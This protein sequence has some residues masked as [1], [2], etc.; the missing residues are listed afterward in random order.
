MRRR[1]SCSLVLVAAFSGC[2]HMPS[3]VRVDGT[4]TR[5]D[6]NHLFYALPRTVVTAEIPITKRIVAPGRCAPY[7]HVA[8]I[9]LGVPASQIPDLVGVSFEQGKIVL[10]SRT[11]PDPEQ[12]FAIETGSKAFQNRSQ[13]LE[14]SEQ[15]FLLGGTSESQSQ[16]ATMAV[17]T[18]STAATLAAKVIPMGAG[19]DTRLMVKD[20]EVEDEEEAVCME[21]A[22][23]IQGIRE[24]RTSL[25]EG[26]SGLLSPSKDA[27]EFMVGALNA[28][29]AR[30]LQNFTGTVRTVSA[31]I[32][33]AF[34]PGSRFSPMSL[35]IPNFMSEPRVPL[36]SFSAFLGL[37]NVA[38]ELCSV[39]PEFLMAENHKSVKTAVLQSLALALE[40]NLEAVLMPLR[41]EI[42]SRIA[43]TPYVQFRRALAKNI[44]GK[45]GSPMASAVAER[46]LAT[47]PSRTGGDTAQGDSGKQA[48][49][50]AEMVRRTLIGAYNP[51]ELRQTVATVLEGLI[52]KPSS[53]P[54][55]PPS[56]PKLRERLSTAILDSLKL[57]E[58][59][60][61]AVQ[62]AIGAFTNEKGDVAAVPVRLRVEVI[63]SGFAQRVADRQRDPLSENKF[64]SA[65]YHYRIPAAAKV[66]IQVDG[67]ERA[68][69]RQL[70]AQF[71]VVTALPAGEDF[72]SVHQKYS[73]SF[74]SETG[75]L[76]TFNSTAT[77]IE[78]S[79]L[80]GV[81]SAAGTLLDAVAAKRKA[82]AESED[83]LAQ[84]KRARALLEETKAIRDLEKELGLG[85]DSKGAP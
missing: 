7:K 57:E 84:L 6:K 64:R 25:I 48:A 31:T 56:R 41:A 68:A 46:F 18:L 59:T 3:V 10:G 24:K 17:Q 16:V 29:E 36:Y 5:L 38:D 49:A 4:E 81:G 30:L 73:A 40:D 55:Q 69:R 45:I 80:T 19:A 82:E 74:H 34:V 70:V 27:V 61:G 58:T 76:K 11:E 21:I 52:G 35:P 9:G 66:W 15:G 37:S 13:T 26:A 79:V 50:D 62:A 67:A 8:W 72:S 43:G 47:A 1:M 63:D 12:V 83:E 53:T 44:A 42:D 71:G 75:A 39:P 33:C 60:K 28:E 78:P 14:F 2:A 85:V 65:G 54:S 20:K 32:S 22:G 23:A 77:G 51:E